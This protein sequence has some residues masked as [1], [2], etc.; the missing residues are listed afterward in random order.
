MVAHTCP[1]KINKT[2]NPQKVRFSPVW[3]L[4]NLLISDRPKLDLLG[5]YTQPT[6]KIYRPNWTLKYI[7]QTTN[8]PLKYNDTRY[9][10]ILNNKK[11][12]RFLIRFLFREDGIRTHGEVT[13]TQPFQDCTLSRSDT[14]L[15]LSYSILLKEFLIVNTF[16]IFFLHKLF[17]T[18]MLCMPKILVENG[19]SANGRKR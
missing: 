13:L 3:I 6:I 17:L 14:S 7:I 19:E 16:V 12:I 4:N 9:Y 1:I 11:R 15:Y 18:F 10:K 8:Q 5:R 2:L